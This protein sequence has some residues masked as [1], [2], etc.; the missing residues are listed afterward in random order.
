[1]LRSVEEIDGA[2]VY[3]RG[4][5]ST[6]LEIDGKNEYFLYYKSD[7]DIGRYS[8][9]DNV[10]EKVLSSS[11]KLYWDQISAPISA[12]QDNIDALFHHKFSIPLLSPCPT[13]VQQ[14]GAEYWLF[15]EW[16]GTLERYYAMLAI[17]QFC[18][19]ANRV[20]TNSRSLAEQLSPY[21]GVPADDMDHIYAAPDPQFS[22]ITSD[23]K[24]AKVRHRYELPETPFFLMV[25][26]GYSSIHSDAGEMYPRKNV[27]GVIQAYRQL[28]RSTQDTPPSLVIAGPGFEEKEMDHLRNSLPND[29]LLEFPGYVEFEDMP[30]VYSM[31]LALV[32]PSYS[33]SFGI[34]LIEAMACGCPVIAS[35]TAA[36]PEVVDEAGLLVDPYSN[37]EIYEALERL[38]ED[39]DERRRLAERGLRRAK[40]FTWRRS[41]EK[42]LAI[43]E[44]TAQGR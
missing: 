16:Y 37:D 28:Q 41:A 18:R 14:R 3:I 25:A 44:E 17:P 7:D 35:N 4:L 31:A 26:K 33:E 43:L 32:F 34:P 8:D 15:P 24:I 19:R 13:V 39:K 42:L 20:L 27:N 9:Y 2:G 40:D 38:K 23:T 1:M 21:V 5:C 12:W 10:S 36:C 11:S 29:D 30:A 6:L 22:P